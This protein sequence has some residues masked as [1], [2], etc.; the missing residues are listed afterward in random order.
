LLIVPP[1][2]QVS[3]L[4]V[5]FELYVSAAA[6]KE[7]GRWRASFLWGSGTIRHASLSTDDTVEQ[8]GQRGYARNR[9]KTRII[10]VVAK[11][12]RPCFTF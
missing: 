5:G 4:A 8:F 11:P 7:T 3:I 12:K 6:D 1:G 10:D 9:W 2:S